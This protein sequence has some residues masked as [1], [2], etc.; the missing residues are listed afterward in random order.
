MGECRYTP[1]CDRAGAIMCECIVL[2]PWD[3]VVWFS[4]SDV[5]LT[6]W[7][8]GIALARGDDATVAEADVAPIQLQGPRA[9]DVLGRPGRRGSRRVGRHRCA[10]MRVAGVDAVVSNTGW[11]REAG[12]EI[13]PLGS[14]RAGELW[15]ALCAAGEPHGMLVTGPNIV[16]AVGGAGLDRGEGVGEPLR[17]ADVELGAGLEPAQERCA[18]GDAFAA[19]GALEAGRARAH[20][21]RTGSGF[22][23][24]VVRADDRD[25]PG[26][27]A[28]TEDPGDAARDT[29]AGGVPGLLLP[30]VCV[31][32][33]MT[34]WHGPS[35]PV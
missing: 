31:A 35:R 16:R 20:R 7:A 18:A 1:V 34:A 32:V 10:P 11:S 9:A 4:H 30:S 5:D 21:H 17:S 13:Y 8:A 12:Y 15:D 28:D 14:G 27:G 29:E 25:Q 24:V 26:D 6:L 19:H 3:D 2:R 23:P 22:G 33:R